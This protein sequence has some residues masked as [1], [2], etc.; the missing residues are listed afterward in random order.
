MS[1]SGSVGIVMSR[2]ELSW[3]P[4]NGRNQHLL[5]NERE[6]ER[7]VEVVGGA[8]A[9]CAAVCCCPCALVHLAV[10]A[11]VKLPVGLCKKAMKKMKVKPQRRSKHAQDNGGFREKTNLELESPVSS[12]R[13]DMLSARNDNGLVMDHS[14]ISTE[15][16][17][18]EVTGKSYVGFWR[19]HSF[20]E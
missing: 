10:L 1:D 14:C 12:S 19:N 7:F 2:E 18:E 3:K 15:E 20:K 5:T 9:E 6:R 13:T 4:V 11:F 16:F 17:W 8:T